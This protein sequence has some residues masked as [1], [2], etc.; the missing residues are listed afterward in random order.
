MDRMQADEMSSGPTKNKRHRLTR[1]DELI[2][3]DIIE[4]R[5]KGIRKVRKD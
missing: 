1:N 5:T 3:V 4:A 2:V